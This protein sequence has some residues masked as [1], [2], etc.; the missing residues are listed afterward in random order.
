MI[1]LAD[2]YWCPLNRNP[3]SK[4]GVYGVEWSAFIYDWKIPYF[5]NIYPNA[6]LHTVRFSPNADK[7]FLRLFDFL[8]YEESYGRNVI[9]KIC[10]GIH[11]EEILQQ[12]AA[13]SHDVVFRNTDEKYMVHS[14]T[15]ENWE[16]I[17]IE[18][19]LLSPNMLKRKGVK[20]LEIGLKQ[21]I[22]PTDY[23]DY[24][25]LDVLNGCGELVIN[26]R[27]LGYVCV[28]PDIEYTPG[29]RL[30][31]DAEKMIQNK[32]ITRDG[33]H[34]LKVKDRLP[35]EDYLVAVILADCFSKDIKW[36]PT[37]FTEEANQLFYMNYEKMH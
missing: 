8:A 33:L 23:S 7:G 9:L 30:Y 4:N 32:I 3:F 1:Y 36:T 13:Y 11:A 18:K 12:Y 10:T 35:L 28:N 31:F 5:T 27:Q 22:E 14:T 29:V 24:I 2:S 21:M 34:L 6:K 17:Q 37:L 16:T 19:A 15:L 25:M 26:S 20:M